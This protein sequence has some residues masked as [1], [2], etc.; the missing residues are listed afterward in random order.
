MGKNALRHKMKTDLNLIKK[1]IQSLI[2]VLPEEID[3]SWLLSSYLSLRKAFLLNYERD[4]VARL[5]KVDQD[6][7]LLKITSLTPRKTLKLVEEWVAG[8]YFNNAMFRMV[9]LAETGLKVLYQK[10]TSRKAPKGNRAY[11][12]LLGWYK[13]NYGL[14]LDIITE[15]RIQ[16]NVFKHDVRS[17]E[18]SK[19]FETMREG[20][21]AFKELLLL[22]A[23]ICS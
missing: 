15:A 2:F 18:R 21:E 7:L 1:S 22:L 12:I 6:N 5:L 8:Y 9:A 11:Y 10:K 3:R 4:A 13:K 20:V 23:Q 17:P 16:I 14:N 19:K